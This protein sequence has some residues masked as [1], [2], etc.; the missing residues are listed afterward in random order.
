MTLSY[1]RSPYNDLSHGRVVQNSDLGLVDT[2]LSK[3]SDAELLAELGR[4]IA[5]NVREE[6]EEIERERDRWRN[7]YSEKSAEYDDLKKDYNE[8]K[9]SYEELS[10]PDA[11]PPFD[12]A[13]NRRVWQNDKKENPPVKYLQQLSDWLLEI[14]NAK[15]KNGEFIIQNGKDLV[16]VFIILKESTKLLFRYIGDVPD[17]A[18][19]WNDNVAARIEDQERRAK[20]TCNERSLKNCKNK[21]PWSGV[22]MTSWMYLA[23]HG[24]HSNEYNLANDLRN[25]IEAFV[26]K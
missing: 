4:R 6:K 9:K 16:P 13:L 25:K 2:A 10:M 20:L 18:Y 19:F 24:T 21:E 7:R 15:Y 8:L 3:A 1:E 22:S 23:S 14:V 12:Y 11:P 26:Y 17:F 5:S